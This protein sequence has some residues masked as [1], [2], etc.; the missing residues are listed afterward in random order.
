[1]AYVH[2]EVLGACELIDGGEYGVGRVADGGE[3][4]MGGYE[5]EE[6]VF[7]AIIALVE[8]IDSLYI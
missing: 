7:A 5:V 8:S 2:Q 1:L 6:P 4:G 3:L